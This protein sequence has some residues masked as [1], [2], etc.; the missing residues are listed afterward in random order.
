M[1]LSMSNN[2]KGKEKGKLEIDVTLEEEAAA[3]LA[4]IADIKATAKQQL[5]EQKEADRLEELWSNSS[6]EKEGEAAISSMLYSS[7]CGI[8]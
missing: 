1:V 5:K 7:K 4:R 8:D 2:K 3:R 6:V